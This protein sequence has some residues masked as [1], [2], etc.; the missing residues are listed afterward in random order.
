LGAKHPD[1]FAAQLAVADD[2]GPLRPDEISLLEGLQAEAAKQLGTTA[3]T[4]CFAC[5]PCPA[6]IHIPEV[7][8]LRNL[9]V[10]Y[11]MVGFGQ[12]RY[13]LFENGSHWFPG[14]KADKCTH[15]GECLPRCPEKL[16]I[17]GLIQESHEMLFTGEG[18][19]KWETT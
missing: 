7:L 16:N 2:D 12:Y 9:A 10:A 1:E 15:C 13:R 14:K 11:D 6:D 8:R 18:K 19:R 5:L 3:C 17:P 4:Q